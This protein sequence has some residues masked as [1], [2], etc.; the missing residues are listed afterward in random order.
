M[1]DISTAFPEFPGKD[2]VVSGDTGTYLYRNRDT[3]GFECPDNC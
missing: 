2:A 3:F 1:Q